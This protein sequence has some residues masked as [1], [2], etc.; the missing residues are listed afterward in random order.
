MAV[1]EELIRVEDDK[2]LSFGNYLM[3]EKKKI[4]DFEFEGDMY[5]VKTYNKITKLEK[6]GRLLYESVSGTTVHNFNLD[7]KEIIFSVEG[8]EDAQITLELDVEQDY[9]LYIGQVQVGK[10]KSNLAGKISF[11]VDFCNGSQQVEIKKV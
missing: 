9:R 2:T 3:D 1:I 6:N 7:E 4:L 8:K 10:M 11:S 5:K